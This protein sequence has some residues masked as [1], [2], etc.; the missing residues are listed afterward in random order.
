M[1]ELEY[2]AEI[3]IF[4]ETKYFLT[5]K[6]KVVIELW[7]DYKRDPSKFRRKKTYKPKRKCEMLTHQETVKKYSDIYDFNKNE[8]ILHKR[9]VKQFQIVLI[10]DNR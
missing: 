7:K 2:I 5:E 1:L 3:Q 6:G 4:K 9:H 10:I 8:W